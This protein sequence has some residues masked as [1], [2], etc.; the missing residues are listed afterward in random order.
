MVC[1]M[2]HPPYFY[3][4]CLEHYY[5]PDVSEEICILAH[6]AIML[7]GFVHV[8][9]TFTVTSIAI[10]WA[11]IM[12]GA[13]VSWNVGLTGSIVLLHQLLVHSHVRW[14]IYM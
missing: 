10:F 4:F 14:W 6:E 7:Y 3:K 11:V 1:I 13:S 2:A 5:L 12:H 9:H 8:V